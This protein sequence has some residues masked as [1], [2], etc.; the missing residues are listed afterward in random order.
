MMFLLVVN[1]NNRVNNNIKSIELNTYIQNK[2][3]INTRNA[4]L[5]EQ[6]YPNHNPEELAPMCSRSSG[7]VTPTSKHGL[8][9]NVKS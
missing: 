5:E 2:P 7:N 4:Y 1:K 3:K 6:L 8:T 9:P